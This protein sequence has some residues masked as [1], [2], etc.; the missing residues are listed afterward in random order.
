MK[1]MKRGFLVVLVLAM[2]FVG[3]V[4]IQTVLV[5]PAAGAR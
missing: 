4:G 2:L 5:R 3:I 1:W